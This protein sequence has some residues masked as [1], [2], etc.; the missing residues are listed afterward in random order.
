MKLKEGFVLYDVK[1]E[2]LVIAAGAAG[3]EFQGMIRNNETAHEIF[4]LLEEERTE[5][6]IVDRLYELYD[7]PREVI[8]GDVSSL[9]AQL[10]QA[11]VLD[12]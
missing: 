2:H 1:D 6:E 12:E 3:K 11:G 8:E 10:R 9:L 7:A 5:P 4:R